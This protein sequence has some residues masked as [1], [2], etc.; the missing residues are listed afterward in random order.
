MNL[1]TKKHFRGVDVQLRGQTT[2]DGG[3]SSA[4][5]KS[6]VTRITGK[7]RWTLA[8]NVSFQQELRQSRRDIKPDT[9]TYFDGIGNISGSNGGEID[10]LLSSLAG[11][12][13]VVAYLVAWT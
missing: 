6:T 3:G 5:G 10:P 2:T 13:V 7:R 1:T 4:T 12:E 9:D 11:D 8:G